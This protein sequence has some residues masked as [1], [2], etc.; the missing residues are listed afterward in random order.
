[1]ADSEVGGRDASRHASSG[2]V[3]P[4]P[5]SVRDF[6]VVQ[7]STVNQRPSRLES[8]NSILTSWEAPSARG[9]G[10]RN[11]FVRDSSD[12]GESADQPLADARKAG[13]ADSAERATAQWILPR[14]PRGASGDACCRRKVGTGVFLIR[15]RMA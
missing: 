12:T 15:I 14:P 1:M 7:N 9:A 6:D 3:E 10:P 5:D 11:P 2:F 4:T 13:P 8:R